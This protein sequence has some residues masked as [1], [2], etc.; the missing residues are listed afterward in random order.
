MKHDTISH[1]ISYYLE[2]P[3][4]NGARPYGNPPLQDLLTRHYFG[5]GGAIGLILSGFGITLILNALEKRS[6][7]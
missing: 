2:I 5:N 6:S 7:K 3:T 1:A 4:R